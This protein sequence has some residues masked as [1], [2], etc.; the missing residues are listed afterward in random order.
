MSLFQCRGRYSESIE[1]RFWRLKSIPT[2]KWWRTFILSRW[3]SLIERSFLRQLNVFI[4]RF[5]F[6]SVYNIIILHQPDIR[7]V[8]DWS[9]W[10]SRPITYLGW[11]TWPSPPTTYLGS[12]TW[13]S[14]PTTYLGSVTL[15]TWSDILGV[16]ELNDPIWHS[17]EWQIGS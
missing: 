3:A 17:S 1:V 10:P 15:D 2:L 9:R 14:Q 16:S 8:R 7:H 6:H 12:V 5:R 4:T 11:V 13:P